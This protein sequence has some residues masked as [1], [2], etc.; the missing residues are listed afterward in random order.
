MPGLLLFLDLQKAFD[1]LNYF[2][3]VTS[4]IKWFQLFYCAP[5]SCILNNGWTSIFL[6]QTRWYAG[7]S[8]LSFSVI[9]RNVAK[10]IRKN[11]TIN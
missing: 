1:T 9:S 7:L 2:G 4:I 6:N 3:F 10:K 8:S 5:E 11:R